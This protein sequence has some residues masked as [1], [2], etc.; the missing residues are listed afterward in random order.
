MLA[1]VEQNKEDRESSKYHS[2]E[3]SKQK[4]EKNLKLEQLKKWTKWKY[5][6]TS[7]ATNALLNNLLL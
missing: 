3:C 2:V 1:K 7:D 5:N 6:T 4:E